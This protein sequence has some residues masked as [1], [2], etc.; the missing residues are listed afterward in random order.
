MARPETDTRQRII[1]AASKLFYSEGIKSVSVDAVAAAAGVTKRTLYYHFDSKDDLI[2]AYLGGRD[3][4]NLALFQRWFAESRGGLP[5]RIEAIFRNLAR[6]ARHPKWKGCGFLRTSAEL[7]NMPG[8]PA[9][10]IGAA[11]KKK[12]ESWLRVTFEAEGIAQ[13]SRLARQILLLLD[14]SFAVVL[15]HRDPS[16][17]ET[18]GEAAASLTSAAMRTRRRA[19]S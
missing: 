6:S 3:Q 14:G 9:I 2:A 17:I 7:A 16:Y 10:R 19:G 4:P 5:A 12:F 8:H 18:A 1:A 11:H 15:L 13:A